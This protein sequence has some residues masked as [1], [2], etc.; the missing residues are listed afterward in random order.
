[1]EF[2]EP[3][4]TDQWSMPSASTMCCFRELPSCLPEKVEDTPLNTTKRWRPATDWLVEFATTG[5][6]GPLL[7]RQVFKMLRGTCVELLVC[8]VDDVRRLISEGVEYAN[9]AAI[10]PEQ[11]THSFKCLACARF[12]SRVSKRDVLA[13]VAQAQV[14][15][16]VVKCAQPICNWSAS[17]LRASKTDLDA[18]TMGI[19]DSI[20]DWKH[21]LW[22]KIVYDGLRTLHSG[23]PIFSDA[24][25]SHVGATFRH[26]LHRHFKRMN[27]TNARRVNYSI[28]TD[29]KLIDDGIKG[30]PEWARL[31]L[32]WFGE[33]LVPA[34]LNRRSL[35]LWGNAGVGK[36][37]FLERLFEAQEWFRADCSEP[38][39]LQGLCEDHRYV[40][41]DEFV[42][43]IVKG[44]E[45]R[46][47]FNKLVSREHVMVRVK[48]A[49]QYEVNADSIRTV[50]SSNEAPLSTDYFKRRFFV[51][52]AT[53]ALYETPPKPRAR[54]LSQQSNLTTANFGMVL[55]EPGD[56][57]GFK[58]AKWLAD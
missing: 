22:I 47:Q 26:L 1:M 35:F 6:D 33:R 38:F 16:I 39:F 40:W 42:P 18:S 44:R 46:H 49:G 57:S 36:T 58:Q 55:V 20:L 52:R 41:L 27:L 37:R 53:N 30:S 17:V 9:G 24:T 5:T 13:L 56:S 34:D 10:P 25:A 50:V 32:D 51:V 31:V 43:E 15:E 8:V 45:Y 23:D 11:I 48:G 29:P 4:L 19:S 14:M 7:R 3:D 12:T 54:K 21:R 2:S 28:C